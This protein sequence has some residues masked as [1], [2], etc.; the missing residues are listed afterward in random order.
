M[1]T[2]CSHTRHHEQVGNGA[3]LLA[4][5]LS[6][7]RSQEPLDASAGQAAAAPPAS[8]HLNPP[9][10]S[11]KAHARVVDAQKADNPLIICC[12]AADTPLLP[13]CIEKV[14]TKSYRELGREWGPKTAESHWNSE[15]PGRRTGS[16]RPR[17]FGADS[18][19][20]RENFPVLR[21]FARRGSRPSFRVRSGAEEPEIHEHWPPENGFRARHCCG[22]PE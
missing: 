17:R 22:A 2:F 16:D 6:Q 9:D 13:R 7:A 20:N 18:L 1:F 8:G 10:I 5:G 12:S 4:S 14:K 21:E 11:G 19:L 15:N 3:I